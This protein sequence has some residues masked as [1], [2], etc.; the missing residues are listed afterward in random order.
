MNNMQTLINN[1]YYNCTLYKSAD[2]TLRFYVEDQ[3][4]DM[5]VLFHSNTIDGYIIITED[6]YNQRMVWRC[7]IV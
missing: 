3:P 1:K 4:V 5:N 6:D 2:E 7:E